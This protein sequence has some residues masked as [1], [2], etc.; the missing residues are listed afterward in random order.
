[1]LFKLCDMHYCFSEAHLIMALRSVSR[2]CVNSLRC[3]LF[4]AFRAQKTNA[5]SPLDQNNSLF[6]YVSTC[7]MILCTLMHLV[8]FQTC[9]LFV[10]FFSGK[11][12][13]KPTAL[14]SPLVFHCEIVSE[15]GELGVLGHTV[16]GTHKI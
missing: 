7:I 5:A 1:M 10:C 4:T 13:F 8:L 2:L 3:V 9:I 16:K 6:I 11:S 15:M 12:I 14:C